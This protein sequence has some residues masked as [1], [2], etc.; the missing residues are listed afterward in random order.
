MEAKDNKTELASLSDSYNLQRVG[1]RNSS[2]IMNRV[3][4]D[5]FFLFFG[6]TCGT[7][8][9]RDYT[10]AAATAQATAVTMLD[11]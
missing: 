4:S 8:K 2:K 9:F 6:H 7:Q 1:K 5:I 11:P 3:R 10:H